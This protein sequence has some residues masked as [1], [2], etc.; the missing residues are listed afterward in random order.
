[1]QCRSCKKHDCSRLRL[2]YLKD[3]THF[4][5]SIDTAFL[6]I[7]CK[8]QSRQ[9]ITFEEYHNYY[10][11]VQKNIIFVES[12]INKYALTDSNVF[13]SSIMSMHE[14][15]FRNSGQSK[16]GQF[17][18]DKVF[19]D[20]EHHGFEGVDANCIDVEL[21]KLIANIESSIANQQ[22]QYRLARLI[23]YFLLEFFRIHPFRDGNGRV[24]RG[25]AKCI[26]DKNGFS[27][28]LSSNNSEKDYLKIIRKCRK[29]FKDNQAQDGTLTKEQCNEE[30]YKFLQGFLIKNSIGEEIPPE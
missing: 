17:R 30:F 26:A 27:F 28:N 29:K 25:I 19:V 18:L 21:K 13:R 23:G 5:Q 10:S 2:D 7:I 24:G 6:E 9:N 12:N 8:D 14:D 15:I 1:M 11:Q 3:P 20:D 4:C 16:L 22:D